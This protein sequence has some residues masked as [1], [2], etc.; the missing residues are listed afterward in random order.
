MTSYKY[1]W[2][3]R[4]VTK[5]LKPKPRGLQKFCLLIRKDYLK[6]IPT[7][8]LSSI[9]CILLKIEEF[10]FLNVHR[11][12]HREGEKG[13]DSTLAKKFDRNLVNAY[14]KWNEE[15]VRVILNMILEESVH[16]RFR[17]VSSGR[18][19]NEVGVGGNPYHNV[20]L[21][22]EKSR[23]IF[24]LNTIEIRSMKL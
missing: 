8:F 19:E 14:D 16:N 2:F 9:S 23:I 20:F 12:L 15:T 13:E 24:I 21:I 5:I 10:Q 17:H 3:S 6:Y 22:T 11:A 18:D 7:Q 4:D 1:S